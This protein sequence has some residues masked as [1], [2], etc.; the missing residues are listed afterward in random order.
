M[1]SGLLVHRFFHHQTPN[2][3][4]SDNGSSVRGHCIQTFC[5]ITDKWICMVHDLQHA[6]NELV[7]CSTYP[8]P[9]V[10][11]PFFTPSHGQGFVLREIVVVAIRKLIVNYDVSCVNS[12]CCC[13]RCG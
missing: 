4:N 11:Q 5:A 3:Q 6:L 10:R 2:M 13:R 7:T 8:N 9:Q 12:C 1:M